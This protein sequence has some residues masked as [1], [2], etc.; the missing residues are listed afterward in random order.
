[1]SCFLILFTSSS[2][3]SCS[4]INSV[5]VLSKSDIKAKK[6]MLFNFE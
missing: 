4:S 2:V 3:Y 5:Q 1:M 6:L